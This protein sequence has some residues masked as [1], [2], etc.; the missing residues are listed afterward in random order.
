MC[1]LDRAITGLARCSVWVVPAERREWAEAL[2]AEACDVPA[3]QRLSWVAGGLWTVIRQAGIVRR[4][5]YWLGV[6]ALALGASEMVSLVWRRPGRAGL[7]VRFGAHNQFGHRDIR[8]SEHHRGLQV[9]G[10][11]D[12]CRL[13]RAAVGG[14]ATRCFR[15]GQ[16]QL[17][18]ASGAGG[19]LRGDLRAGARPCP[20]GPDPRRESRGRRAGGGCNCVPDRTSRCRGAAD[21]CARGRSAGFTV[22]GTRPKRRLRLS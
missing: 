18:R 13:G 11:H 14:P 9:A 22:R 12:D 16:R 19:G 8:R 2:W 4:L 6:A 7:Q 5:A 15:P 1:R 20:A 21:R 3:H 17:R 10:D